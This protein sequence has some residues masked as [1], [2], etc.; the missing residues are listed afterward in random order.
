MPFFALYE[1]NGTEIPE[2]RRFM[3]LR[4]QRYDVTYTCLKKSPITLIGEKRDHIS[5]LTNE[6]I[7]QHGTI[8][9]V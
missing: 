2:Q 5:E 4:N 3:N 9:R 8:K 7:I 1:K 6:K